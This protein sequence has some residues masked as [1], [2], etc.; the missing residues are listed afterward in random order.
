MLLH[1]RTWPEVETYLKSS[2]RMIMPIGS[3]EQH[4]PV[5]LIGTDA[6]CAEVVAQSLGEK[7]GVIVAPTIAVGMAQHHLGFPGSMA[8][9]PSTL[10]AVICDMVNSLAVQGFDR[11]FFVLCDCSGWSGSLQRFWGWGRGDLHVFYY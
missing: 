4:G 11:F 5:G 10:L 8:L 6:I 3:T 2:T 1:T 9:R 7:L